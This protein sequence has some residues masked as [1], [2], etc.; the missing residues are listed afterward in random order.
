MDIDEVAEGEGGW[1]GITVGAVRGEG[2]GYSG[3]LMHEL[4]G[5]DLG[6]QG[7]NLLLELH[8][9]VRGVLG[10]FGHN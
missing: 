6:S 5:L 7:R 8:D 3:C 2:G 1:G 4:E 9:N 10:G